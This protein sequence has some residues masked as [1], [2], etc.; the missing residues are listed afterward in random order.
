MFHHSLNQ[1]IKKLL[2][3]HAYMSKYYLYYILIYNLHYR[4][5]KKCNDDGVKSN[6]HIQ[7]KIKMGKSFEV[8]LK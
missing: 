1:K 7:S 4:R 6:K 8:P 2:F 5:Q 3:T